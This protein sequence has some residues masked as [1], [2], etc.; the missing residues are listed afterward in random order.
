[1]TWPLYNRILVCYNIEYVM[2]AYNNAYVI[3]L[4]MSC[5]IQEIFMLTF[6]EAITKY[7]SV[8]N[9]NYIISHTHY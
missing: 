9:N 3:K 2:D 1:M 5:H 4:I 6:L 8:C 7:E